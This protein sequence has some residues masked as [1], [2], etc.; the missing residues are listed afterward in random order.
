[1]ITLTPKTIN[2][3]LQATM[4]V[5]LFHLQQKVNQLPYGEART[6]YEYSL[7][8]LRAAYGLEMK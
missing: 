1:M 6:E 5:R 7:N 3:Q 8:N 4:A 2:P